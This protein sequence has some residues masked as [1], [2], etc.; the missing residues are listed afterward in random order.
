ME[1]VGV[2]PNYKQ[3]VQKYESI[4]LV[5]T[6]SF[7][8]DDYVTHTALEGL[9]QMVAEEEKKIRTDPGARVTKLLKTVFGK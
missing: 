3:I 9:F 2:T 1:E 6:V 8:L 7:D 5:K 4:P